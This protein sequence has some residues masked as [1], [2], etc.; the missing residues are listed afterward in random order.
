MTDELTPKFPSIRERVNTGSTAKGLLQPD[1]TVEFT[2]TDTKTV[3]KM[4]KELEFEIVGTE[5][6][7]VVDRCFAL[8]KK[9]HFNAKK[10]G[11]K[12]V[13]DE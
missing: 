9:W 2:D 3:V 6:Q 13:F 5:N 12:T 11:Y 10:E 4:D 1:I 7:D 8:M